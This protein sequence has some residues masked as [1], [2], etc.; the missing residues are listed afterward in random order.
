MKSKPALNR[1]ALF[2]L[3]NAL[4]A[5]NDST[6]FGDVENINVTPN[7]NT[8]INQSGF[9]LVDINAGYQ[10]CNG[11]TIYNELLEQTYNLYECNNFEIL[12]P[13]SSGQYFNCSGYCGLKFYPL[14][15]D[16]FINYIIKY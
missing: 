14:E 13:I 6:N 7:Q 2:F 5:P 11:I 4:N 15:S 16:N 10:N 3:E 1:C 9:L 12:I 8:Q